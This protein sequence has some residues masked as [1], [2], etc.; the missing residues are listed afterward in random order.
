MPRPDDPVFY[1]I[2]GSGNFLC[3]NHEMFSA[4]VAVE[5]HPRSLSPHESLCRLN[6][7]KLSRAA[8][9]FIVGFFGTIFEIHR[10]EAIVLL[11]WDPARE[12]YRLCVPPQKATVWQNLDGSR[13]PVD[14]V[15][16]VPPDW[17]KRYRI[18]GDIHSH[19]NHGAYASLTDRDD[20][21]YRDGVH[22]VFGDI[23]LEPPSFSGDFSVDGCRFPL[24]FGD[25]FRGYGRRRRMI[26][27]TWLE[28][29]AVEILRP[30]PPVWQ[31]TRPIN[32]VN[33]WESGI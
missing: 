4:D 27:R 3:R 9:E 19:G 28:S 6:L 8:L 17:T 22:V 29:V 16:Q 24:K 1:W 15:Y 30:P 32:S 13:W 21:K 10:S 26:P 2:T 14:V 23:Q 11:F 20:E 25:I 33:R 7:P 31:V 12:R 18:I 5:R